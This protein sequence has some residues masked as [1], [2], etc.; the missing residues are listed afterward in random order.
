MAKI[1]HYRTVF[2]SDIHLGDADC[3]ADFLLDFLNHSRIDTLYLI[4]DIIDMWA[5]SRQFCWPDSHNKLLHRFMQM[6][7][8]GT[9]VIYLPGNHDEPAQRYDGMALGEIE[10]HREYIHTLANGKKLLLMHGDQF[11]QEVCF[12][13]LHAWL[14]DKA[15]RSLMF[16]NRW[17]NRYRVWRGHDY[18]SLAGFLKSHVRGASEAITRYREIGC[19]YARQR[20]L[21]GIVCGHIHHPEV[22]TVSGTLYCND[23][24]WVENCSALTEDR[25]GNLQLIF[26]TGVKQSIDSDLNP[27]GATVHKLR[28][29]GARAA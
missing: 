9:R 3:K 16:V 1:T 20:G 5:M 23:G 29:L 17:Y 11:D 15:Y 25:R 27:Q 18:W 13:P 4:G 6:P 10:I 26:W 8:A 2:L 14:G 7:S 24:D 28:D 21:D 22:T 12:G 19:A